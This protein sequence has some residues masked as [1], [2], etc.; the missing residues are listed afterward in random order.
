[1]KTLDSLL[2]KVGERV[3]RR[4]LERF[5]EREIIPAI[6]LRLYLA[7][8]DTT[9][10]V[11]ENTSLEHITDNVVDGVYRLIERILPRKYLTFGEESLN[12]PAFPNS[13]YQ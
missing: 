7:G 3:V 1:M 9:V 2:N 8:Y 12:E 13:N 5:L 11:G 4:K 10:P 6:N